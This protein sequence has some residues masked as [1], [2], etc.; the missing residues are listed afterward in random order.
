MDVTVGGMLKSWR[1]RRRCSQLDLAADAQ[2]SAK[3]ISF[4]E[5]GRSHPSAEMLLILGSALELPLRERNAL[6]LAGGYAPVYGEGGLDDPEMAPV[7][8]AL[9]FL[10]RRHEPHAAL[11]IDTCWNIRM[12]NDAHVRFLSWLLD[13]PLP[14]KGPGALYEEPPIVGVNLLHA[15]LD[16]AAL[17]PRLVNFDAVACTM[18]GWLARDALVDA[19]AAALLE[20]L[21]A[22][23]DLPDWRRGGPAAPGLLELVWDKGGQRVSFFSMLTAPVGPRDVVLEALRVETFFPADDASERLVEQLH[24]EVEPA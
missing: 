22:Y 21:C 14:S 13:V 5:T 10:L 1:H 7:R 19:D 6:L 24:T 15:L 20:E 9:Q 2:V 8:R 23:P 16:P 3:H 4:I 12:A 11:V 17:R 18:L